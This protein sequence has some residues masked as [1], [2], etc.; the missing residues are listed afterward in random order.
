VPTVRLNVVDVRTDLSTVHRQ[1]WAAL[2]MPGTWWTGEQRIELAA[3]ALEAMTEAAALAPW[4]APSTISGKLPARPAAPG[5]AHDAIYRVARH[6]GTLTDTWYR[7]VIH[8]LGD[9]RGD[10]AY[11]ELV[12]I[13]C[14]VSAVVAFRRA[15][16]LP[17]WTLPDPVGGEPSQTVPANLVDAQ[18][19]WVRV[20]APADERA[21]VVQAFTSVPDEHHRLWMLADAQYI[22]DLEMVDPQWTRGTLSRAQMELVAARVSQLRECFY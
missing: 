5:I 13:A 9:E 22:P 7:H 6:A 12:A 20:T 4:T 3:T 21:A 14:T 16:G 11:V 10:V 17:A 15:A 8:E 18:L 2:G 1:A 19:N